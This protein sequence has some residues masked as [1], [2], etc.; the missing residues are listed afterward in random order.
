MYN[1]NWNK[2]TLN[3]Q[4]LGRFGEYYAKMALASY[5]MNIFTSEVDDHGI[6]FVAESKKGFLKFQVKTIRDNTS[7]VFMKKKY[8]NIFDEFLFLLLIIL[9]DGEHPM[10]FAI[11]ATAWQSTDKNA[12]VFHP[13]DNKKSEPEYGINISKK[14]LPQIE[15]YCLEKMIAR[16]L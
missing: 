8:F 6:D 4:K 2:E 5:G 7:Y 10:L 9:K 16:M 12:F 3:K 15:E 13:Y 1:L 11:P 14:N